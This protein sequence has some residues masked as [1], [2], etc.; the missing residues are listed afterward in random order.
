MSRI[1]L[2]I[3]ATAL[4][5]ALTACLGRTP[6]V[7]TEVPQ[8]TAAAT[9][10]ATATSET[11]PTSEPPTSALPTATTAGATPVP[12]ETAPAPKET[13]GAA[14]ETP[15][16]TN[17][18]AAATPDPNQGVGEN[19]LFQDNLDGTSGWFWTFSDEV[20][21]FGVVDGQLKG[22]MQAANAGWRFTI[23]PDTLNLS[24]Q[25]VR[26]TA[27]TVACGDNDEYGLMFRVKPQTADPDQYD[28][29]L[30][31]L[32][33]SGAARV[34]LVQGTQSTPVVDWTPSPAINTGA[35][36]DNT[37]LIWSSGGE[38][39]FYVNDQ[40]LFTAQDSNLTS[41]FYGIYL[42]DRTAGGMTVNFDDL[43]AREVAP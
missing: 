43:I 2:L 18:T 30:F 11:P 7:D 15:A 26:L 38:H 42:Y 10:A 13:A 6:I 28:G 37:L 36:V 32:R 1:P 35:G 8:P 24:R 31:K 14:T 22:V 21:T 3:A 40:Y 5:L 29:Y 9:E 16:A 12:T 27:H 17:T 34:D 25:Q 39:R 20:A 41:G 23:S 19:I 33:C 4:A